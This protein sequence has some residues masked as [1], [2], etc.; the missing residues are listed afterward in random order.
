MT[1][2]RVAVGVFDAAFS[3]RQG[4][5]LESLETTFRPRHAEAA[6]MTNATWAQSSTLAKMTKA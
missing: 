3:Q 1:K 4:I 5:D 2:K 6:R